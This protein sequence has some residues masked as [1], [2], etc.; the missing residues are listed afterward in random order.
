[1]LLSLNNND[2]FISIHY[3]RP[4]DRFYYGG[5][6]TR[7][8]AIEFG[9]HA[10][11]CDAESLVLNPTGLR[12]AEKW[13]WRPSKCTLPSW[14]AK[15]FCSHLG[16]RRILFVGDSLQEQFAS[17]LMALVQA[18]YSSDPLGPKVTT[19]NGEGSSCHDQIYFGRA[20]TIIGECMGNGV[21]R[22][23]DQFA[24]NASNPPLFG[25]LSAGDIVIMNANGHVY[26]TASQCSSMNKNRRVNSTKAKEA[27]VKIIDSVHATMNL[28]RKMKSS[29][30][31]VI[32]RSSSPAHDQCSQ[33]QRPE[34]MY[35]TERNGT[36]E[37]VYDGGDNSR[38]R[39]SPGYNHFL[40]PTMDEVVKNHIAATGAP[41]KFMDMS[42]LY[43]R[44]DAHTSDCF[45]YCAPGPWN[46]AARVFL[47]WLVG[48]D[49]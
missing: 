27:I 19:F 13:V 8:T 3:S 17:T 30:P 6:S 4:K 14:D 29:L 22:P 44:P 33:H 9:G 12:A 37:A 39:L 40:F 2:T 15:L 43:S 31:T 21:G 48:G 25:S 41:I 5:P 1:M 26:E 20:D 45:H 16:G 24:F 49:V 28:Q 10:C 7:T 36:Y 46:D 35:Y 11:S 18:G 38:R 42:M 47:G 23:W 32:W 34:R